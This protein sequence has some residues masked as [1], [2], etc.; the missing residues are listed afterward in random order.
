M[1]IVWGVLALAWPLASGAAPVSEAVPAWAASEAARPVC[2]ERV[3]APAAASVPGDGELSQAGRWVY[4][5]PQ[6]GL[7]AVPPAREAARMTNRPVATLGFAQGVTQRVLAGGVVQATRP[8]GF[9][10]ALRATRAADGTLAISHQPVAA[11]SA[12]P[13]APANGGGGGE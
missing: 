9:R 6:T 13:A 2:S 11:A 1:R 4:R 10:V 7:L 5:D 8:G 3:P 12:A